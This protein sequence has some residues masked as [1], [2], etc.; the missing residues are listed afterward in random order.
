M[1]FHGTPAAPEAGAPESSAPPTED[2]EPDAA[3]EGVAGEAADT[4]GPATDERAAE[5]EE[6]MRRVLADLDN[7]RKRFEREVARERAAERSRTVAAWLPVVDDLERALD[8]GAATAT[9]TGTAADP[10]ADPVVEGVRAVRDHALGLLD[11]L[12]FP[13]FDDL[14]ERFDPVRHEAVSAIEADAPPGTVVATV[15]PGYG[16][17]DQILR[18]AAVVVAKS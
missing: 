17:D 3:T 16:R 1:S 9:A 11:R 7:L 14:G 12:G 2:R 10:V 6:P 13:R 15:R 4:G 5:L 18:P 8:A